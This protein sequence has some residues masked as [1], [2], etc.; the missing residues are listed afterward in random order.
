MPPLVVGLSSLYYL[1]ELG[2]GNSF[3]ALLIT[4]T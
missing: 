1:S 3:A 2:I 4:H